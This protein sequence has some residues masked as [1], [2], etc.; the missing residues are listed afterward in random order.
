MTTFLLGLLL[1]ALVGAFCMFAA[2]VLSLTNMATNKAF[3]EYVGNWLLD[4]E[5]DAI[6]EYIAA[7]KEEENQDNSKE[8][9]LI[10]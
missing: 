9:Q 10:S 6:R 7:K 8:E 5:R 2:V 1:G 4:V 3:R